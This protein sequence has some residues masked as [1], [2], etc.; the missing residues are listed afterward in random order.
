VVVRRAAAEMVCNSGGSQQ[1]AMERA[2]VPVAMAGG[3]AAVVGE[4]CQVHPSGRFCDVNVI[5]RGHI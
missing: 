4:A 3:V 2:R 5:R 1:E